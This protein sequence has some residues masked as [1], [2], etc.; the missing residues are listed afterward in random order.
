ML[1][2]CQ[3]A[4]KKKKKKKKRQW[5]GGAKADSAVEASTGITVAVMPA[6]IGWSQLLLA[7]VETLAAPTTVAAEVA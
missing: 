4:T 7:A 6:D 2:G 5:Y 3:S 1:L